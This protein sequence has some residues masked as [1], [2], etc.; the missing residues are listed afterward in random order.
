MPQRVEVPGVG[1]LEFPD[2][3]TDQEMAAAIQ[4][5]F[6]QQTKPVGVGEDVAKTI[7]S[8]AARGVTNLAGAPAD[9]M[10][11]ITGN[12]AKFAGKFTSPET[13]ALLKQHAAPE[14]PMPTSDRLRGGVEKVTGELYKPQTRAGKFVGGVT[15]GVAGA[16][17]FGKAQAVLGG[18]GGAASET[19]GALTNDNPWAKA[20]AGIGV[21]VGAQLAHA[22]RSVPGNMIRGAAGDITPEQFEEARQLMA[23]AKARGIDLM[24]P[25]ALGASSVQQL[26]SDVIGSKEGGRVMNQFLANRPGQVK[27][28]VDRGLL[29]QVGAANT[30]DV[31]M[32]RAREAATD[33]IS[34]AERARTAA[35]KPS[36]Q[37]ARGDI[38]PPEN[39]QAIVS[40]IDEALP[41]MSAESRAAAETFKKSVVNT[42]VNAAALDDLY[43]TTRNRIELP[44]IG[45]TPEQKTAA[46]VLRPFNSTLDESLRFA[47]P[48]IK[49][50]REQ[51]AQISRDVVD[52]LTS[53]PVGRVAGKQG[54]D[55]SMPENL[56]P[57]SAVANEKLARPESI[58][59]LYT[60]LNKQD[61]KAFP[62][63]ARTWLENAFDGAAQKVQAGENRMV[64]ANFTKAVYGTPQQEA[65]F[66]ETMRG[67]AIANG[68]NPDEFAKGAKN[69]MEIL[70]ATGKVGGAGSPTGGRLA[71]NEQASRSALSAGMRS[72]STSPLSPLAK[73]ID[74]WTMGGNYK[75]LAEI[76]TAP[77]AIDQII[78]L[79]KYKNTTTTSMALAIGLLEGSSEFGR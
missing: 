51:F 74:E 45:A 79:G 57:V 50:G 15:E 5:N 60:N 52:P 58:R 13:A 2:G 66:L 29:S 71:S 63:I 59:E 17:P 54:F 31:N 48:N 70:Q 30:P 14:L 44:P 34:G 69:L 65:N 64:G 56:N 47:S 11:F 27:G 7:P 68:K 36:Y 4:R 8:A 78:R 39:I 10:E 21:P 9:L 16:G 61:P 32:A 23:R 43:K 19:A 55:P 42:P 75:R 77:D 49:K 67:V 76:L 12:L 18:I 25:E 22:Y 73:R 33:V 62:G 53:G 35:V 24:A 26:A 40:Q 3:M 37:A 6:P 1:L 28:A 46:G 72:L 38:M 41:F 20:A